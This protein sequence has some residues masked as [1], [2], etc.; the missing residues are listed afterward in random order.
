MAHKQARDPDVSCLDL[1][2]GI[3]R[4]EGAGAYIGAMFQDR[5]ALDGTKVRSV[6]QISTSGSD[7]VASAN[8]AG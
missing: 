8:P 4:P 1:R 3:P 6:A 7:E 2:E 5:L